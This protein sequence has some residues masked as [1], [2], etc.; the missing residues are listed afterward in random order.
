M[1]V[2]AA[3]Y[4]KFLSLDSVMQMSLWGIAW[5][6]LII[7]LVLAARAKKLGTTSIGKN[8]WGMLEILGFPL[9]PIP[10]G[11][12]PFVKG[13]FHVKQVSTA[14]LRIPMTARREI[15]KRVLLVSITVWVTVTKPAE[16]SFM[17]RLYGFPKRFLEIRRDLIAALYG[18]IDE[19]VDDAENPER[20]VQTIDV[21]E[22]A[23]RK[24]LKAS[25]NVD[26]VTRDGLENICGEDLR[27]SLG[28][29][30]R[31]VYI[32]ED[33]PVDGQLWKEGRQIL[34]EEEIEA[35][36]DMPPAQVIGINS[37]TKS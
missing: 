37:S 15:N 24:I 21:I 20:I 3:V 1:I 18:A 34:I 33:A 32:R 10:F 17:E 26:D 35:D 29:Y 2:Q 23:T 5:V 28:E 36:N 30:I 4:D 14:P 9:I 6:I 8:E 16:G 13:V 25:T 7:F 27:V 31:K 19:N 11:L 12:W 22:D